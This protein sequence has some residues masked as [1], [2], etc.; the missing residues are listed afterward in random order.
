MRPIR[1][2]GARSRSTSGCTA[3][4][5]LHRQMNPTV[6]WLQNARKDLVEEYEA[7]AQPDDAARF[8]AELERTKP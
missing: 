6:S 1:S 2:I 3:T 5:I 7:L 8:R 4:G